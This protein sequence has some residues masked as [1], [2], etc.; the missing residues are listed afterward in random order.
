MKC[1][2]VCNKECKN[3]FCQD[4]SF[5]FKQGNCVYSKNKTNENP[6]LMYNEEGVQ[7]TEILSFRYNGFRKN[8]INNNCP[9]NNTKLE[10]SC[11]M[12][13]WGVTP[14]LNDTF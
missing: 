9:K 5:S 10:F 6:H 7:L 11:K 1:F 4:Q 13:Q 2:T 3:L 12:W 8:R 14:P